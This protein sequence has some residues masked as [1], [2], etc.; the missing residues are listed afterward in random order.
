MATSDKIGA[1]VRLYRFD[2]PIGAFLLLWPTL[3]ALWLAGD[4]RPDPRLLVVFVLGT[5]V[6]R[7]AGCAIND[8]A[9]RDFDAHVKRTSTRPLATGE[10]QPN[11]ALVAF[12]VMLLIALILALQLNALS[13]AYAGVGALIAIAYPYMK[14]MTHLPQLW[15]GFAFSWGIPIAFAAETGAVPALAWWLLLAN[16]AWVMA[17]DTQYAMVDRDDDLRI[18]VKSTAV[19]LADYDRVVVSGSHLLALILL[20]VVAMIAGLNGWFYLGLA[21]AA[22]FAIYQAWLCRERD[23]DRCF[24]AFLNNNWFGASIFFGLLLASL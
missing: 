5:F 7:A 23:R 6:M 16:T 19:L 22:M 18:G 20:A 12:M 1:V 15:L 4:G 2:R 21:L 24:T 8:Y 14:R 9:D 13:I 11:E 17:Y 10:L 3:W